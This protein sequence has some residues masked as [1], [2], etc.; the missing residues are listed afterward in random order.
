MPGWYSNDMYDNFFTTTVIPEIEVTASLPVLRLGDSITLTCS[1]KRAIP[2]DNTTFT[3]THDSTAL[4][5][6]GST[7]TLS[8]VRESDRG[9]YR[10]EV[11]N[12][13]GTG[14]G[15]LNL[16]IGGQHHTTYS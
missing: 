7:L 15:I 6:T 10:C 8:P 13:A 5:E 9:V 11:T 1:V 16:E 2:T 12:F 4:P 3:W 14:S